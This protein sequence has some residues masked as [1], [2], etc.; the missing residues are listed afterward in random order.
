MLHSVP[1]NEAERYRAGTALLLVHSFGAKRSG[2]DDFAAFVRATSLSDPMP[3]AIF[4]LKGV[5]EV[6]L[7]AGWVADQLP[8]KAPTAASRMPP[9]AARDGPACR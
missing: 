7:F 8:S 9:T 1:T 4:G 6:D 5:G 2:W 3:N